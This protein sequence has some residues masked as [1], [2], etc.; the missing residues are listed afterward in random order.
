VQSIE[1]WR[2][3]TRKLAFRCRIFSVEQSTS[4]SPTDG[5][6][7]EFFRIQSV[8]WAQLVPVTREGEIVMIRQFRHG[9]EDI[10][11]ECPGGLVDEGED[12]AA[13]AARECLEETG[14]RAPSVEPLSVLNPNPALFANRLHAFYALDVEQIAAPQRYATEHTEVVLL[15]V[16]K[17][18]TLLRSGAINHALIAGTLWH[19]LAE[20]AEL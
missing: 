19:F 15:P 6:E 17:L 9:S 4:V 18:P 20:Y 11:L 3:L 1:A 14:Y 12:P 5:S 7:H 13:T 8:D 2:T 16:P 10:T